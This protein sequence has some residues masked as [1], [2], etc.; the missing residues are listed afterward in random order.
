MADDIVKRLL[1]VAAVSEIIKDNPKIYYDAAHEITRLRERLAEA[2]EANRRVSDENE[3]LRVQLN[4]QIASSKQLRDF[5][6]QYSQRYGRMRE[7][8]KP[9]AYYASQI[10][11]DVSN[12]ASASGTVGDLRAAAAALKETDNGSV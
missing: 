2:D 11:E 3:K 6:V 12:T 9:F 4:E 1:K 5:I 7:A 10:P 8:L